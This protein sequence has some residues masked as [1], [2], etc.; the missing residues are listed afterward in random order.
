M[1][2]MCTSCKSLK[3][4]TNNIASLYLNIPNALFGMQETTREASEEQRV[5]L[6]GNMELSKELHDSLASIQGFTLSEFST[7]VAGLLKELV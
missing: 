4:I 3:R 1:V 2:L 7:T 5:L 6:N